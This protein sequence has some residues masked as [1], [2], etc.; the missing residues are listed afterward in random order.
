M[1]I[2]AAR[3]EFG[4]KDQRDAACEASAPLQQATRDDEPG[5]EAYCFAADPCDD[6]IMQVYEL[7]NGE[8]SL[9]AHFE[10]E[11]YFNLRALLGEMGIIGADDNKYR[12][13]LKEPVYD[14]SRIA[15]ADFF[16]AS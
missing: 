8:A 14:E 15:R 10:H 11:N 2:I 9:A 16:T 4:T 13:D 12:C 6:T 3:I 5:C 7:W 1:I